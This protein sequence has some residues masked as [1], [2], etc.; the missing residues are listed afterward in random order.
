MS[1]PEHLRG[2]GPCA[3]CGTLENIVWHTD[4]VLWNAVT[5]EHV[6]HEQKPAG[7]LC[8]ACFIT[9]FDRAGYKT[10]GWRLIPEWGWERVPA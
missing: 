6:V 1:L 4:N 2:D 5:G 3:D 9:R 7:I 8:V 10:S